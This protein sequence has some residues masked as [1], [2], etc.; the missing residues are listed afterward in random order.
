VVNPVQQA[1]KSALWDISEWD[2]AE[3]SS[4]DQLLDRL[5]ARIETED[6][7]SRRTKARAGQQRDALIAETAI[8]NGLGSGPGD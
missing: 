7:K 6:K 4:D 8:K 2:E 3:W 5:L 1:T